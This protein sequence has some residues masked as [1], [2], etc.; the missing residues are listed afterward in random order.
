MSQA[1][2]SSCHC[3]S[4]NCQPGLPNHRTTANL[5]PSCSINS[6]GRH[7]CYSTDPAHPSC[8]YEHLVT[9]C[10]FFTSG[11]EFVSLP[12]PQ[13]NSSTPDGDPCSWELCCRL[14][15]QPRADQCPDQPH[16]GTPPSWP[17]PEVQGCIRAS[18]CHA[19]HSPTQPKSIRWHGGISH[20]LQYPILIN[21]DFVFKNNTNVNLTNRRKLCNYSIIPPT[22][23][24]IQSPNAPYKLRNYKIPV[25]LKTD[26]L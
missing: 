8:D 1:R 10:A 2:Y 5:G 24:P 11:Y 19:E 18:E 14:L 6:V 23:L 9:R 16:H 15:V 22:N 13:H 3:Y 20:N 21:Y 25:L 12:Y 26:N 17:C 4:S 7:N